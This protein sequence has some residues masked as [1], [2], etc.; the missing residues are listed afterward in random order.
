MMPAAVGVAVS[1]CYSRGYGPAAL[2]LQLQS[3]QTG[4]WC[5]LLLEL[6][7]SCAVAGTMVPAVVGVTVALCYGRGYG[8]R[9]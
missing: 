6:L 3:V 1:M 8:A 7:F 2:E 5:P 4:L 9:C